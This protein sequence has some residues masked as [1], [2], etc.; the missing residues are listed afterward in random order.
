MIPTTISENGLVFQGSM[1]SIYVA[2]ESEFSF[3]FLP[4]STETFDSFFALLYSMMRITVYISAFLQ[5]A[6]FFLFIVLIS[7]M[8]FLRLKRY[9][10]YKKIFRLVLF[11]STPMA[12]LL[13]F[14]NL[15]ALPEWAFFI[16]MFVGYRSIF[17]LQ[18]EL[19]YQTMI[20]LQEQA[21]Q[22]MDAPASGK[23]LKSRMNR[24][25]DPTATIPKTTSNFWPIRLE[26]HFQM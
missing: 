9:I 11:A 15:L 22:T 7:T 26:S 10:P 4:Q 18:R 8:S 23:K 16:L 19:F 12:V 2:G 17:V 6:F 13:T 1:V 20:H 3:A 5:N 14:Y 21:K 24:S 25:K